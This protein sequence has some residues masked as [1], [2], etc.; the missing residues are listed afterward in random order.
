MAYSANEFVEANELAEILKGLKAKAKKKASKNFRAYRPLRKFEAHDYDGK[1]LAVIAGNVGKNIGVKDH[2]P[3]AKEIDSDLG[4]NIKK[5]GLD[6]RRILMRECTH[7]SPVAHSSNPTIIT[8][9]K[10]NMTSYI[11]A[12]NDYTISVHELYSKEFQV[13]PYTSTI[14]TIKDA[15]FGEIGNIRKDLDA[16]MKKLNLLPVKHGDIRYVDDEDELDSYSVYRQNAVLYANKDGS[17]AFGV[18]ILGTPKLVS[19]TV[20]G[21]DQDVIDGITKFIS[22][23][24]TKYKT[25]TEER[26]DKTFYTISSSQ[27][28]F[29]LEDLNIKAEHIDAIINDN[30][31]DDF[32][33]VN[34]VVMEAIDNDKKGLI[35]LHGM[36]GSGKTSYIKHLITGNSKR[37]IVYIPTHLTSAIA[38]PNFISF[39]KSELSNAVLVVE[40]AES[41]LLSRESGES[42]KEAVANILNMTDGILADALNIL[43]ICTFN[44]DMQNLDKALLRKGRLLLEYKFEKLSVEKTD[45]LCDKLYGR[46][47]GESLPLSEIYGLDYEL[48]KP[49]E[50]KKVKFGFSPT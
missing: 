6:S 2:Y 17:Q 1:C 7:D 33:R 10:D 12:V 19:I 25:V 40:D 50:P 4:Q 31:N 39:V 44:T 22:E 49:V 38:S 36:P 15:P 18:E 42:H 37:K 14:I 29:E 16:H 46:K 47:V 11:R 45:A 30:Y 3:S 26:K 9:E 41:V 32:I 13:T 23:I 43:I 27:R 20:I 28:G 34:D 24:K 5:I 35:L 21:N 8:S 48:I